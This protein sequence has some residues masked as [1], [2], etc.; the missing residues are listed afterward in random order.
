MENYIKVSELTEFLAECKKRRNEELLNLRK[1]G[2]TIAGYFC[3]YTP[4]E[5]LDSCGTVPVRVM[6][7]AAHDLETRGGRF[8]RSDSC[9]FCKAALGSLVDNKLFNCIVTG[10]TC[11]QMR[12]IQEIIYDKF[13]IPVY[14]F[15]NPRSF[16]KKS[17][18][19]LFRK[20]MKWIISELCNLSGNDYSHSRLLDRVNKWNRVREYL[21]T[22]HEKRK[23][24]CPHISGA[25]MFDLI[26]T[27]FY[28]GPE[29]FLPLIPEIDSIINNKKQYVKPPLRIMFAGSI[30]SSNDR[31]IHNLIERDGK[32]VIV[33]DLTCSGIRWFKD[34]IDPNEDIFS[35]TCSYYYLNMVCPHRKPNYPLF[36]FAE[37]QFSGWRPD[38]I[39]IR[40]LEFCHPWSFEVK[41][42]KDTFKIPVLH[43]DTDYSD[44]NTGQL[45]TRIEAFCEMLDAKKH[46]N[47]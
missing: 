24:E 17:V 27:A 40:T 47:K 4:V 8:I 28:L 25:E 35:S 41:S 3:I 9:S 10:N 22:V 44:S 43:L 26:N 13:S 1:N 45:R 14:L 12:R 16:G 2:K 37:E 23:L 18:E 34:K 38:G 42:F 21:N 11:D 32:A 46:L 33:S 15:N 29:V 30:C 39:V 19:E 7:D 6:P 5:L 20:E 31:I 36:D